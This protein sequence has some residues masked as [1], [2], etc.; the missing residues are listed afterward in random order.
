MIFRTHCSPEPKTKQP[1]RHAL[2]MKLT[3]TSFEM[4]E[5]I[6]SV[7]V[8][9]CVLTIGLDTAGT[10]T[11][12]LKSTTQTSNLS[13][14]NRRFI[15]YLLYDAYMKTDDFQLCCVAKKFVM[16]CACTDTTTTKNTT[17]TPCDV[18]ATNCTTPVPPPGRRT[19]PPPQQITTTPIPCGVTATNCSTPVT[20]LGQTTPAPPTTPT[21]CACPGEPWKITWKEILFAALGIASLLFQVVVNY[22]WIRKMRKEHD[23]VV[24]SAAFAQDTD[25]V[26]LFLFT[27]IKILLELAKLSPP[28]NG[29]P[30]CETSKCY[31]AVHNAIMVMIAFPFELGHERLNRV[32]LKWQEKRDSE[33]GIASGFYAKMSEFTIHTAYLVYD[34]VNEDAPGTWSRILVV[35][36]C[37]CELVLLKVGS[38]GLH[39]GKYFRTPDHTREQTD[40][41]TEASTGHVSQ[42]DSDTAETR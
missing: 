33:N 42:L 12:V 8:V 36:A 34:A 29:Y 38:P 6:L 40:V 19:T 4:S 14:P 11:T 2:A 24:D 13:N 20:T 31:K 1:F 32:K 5:K 15:E 3:N 39:F 9:A 10:T 17:P 41:V 18:N 25:L 7:V 16:C 23:A 26:I 21:C 27:I 28:P 37:L 30:V 35:A 22:L